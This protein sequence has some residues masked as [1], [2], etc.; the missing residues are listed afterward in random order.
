M[1]G[2]PTDAV[3]E[4]PNVI[5]LFTFEQRRDSTGARKEVPN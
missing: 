2:K 1:N 5:I 4:R 3:T